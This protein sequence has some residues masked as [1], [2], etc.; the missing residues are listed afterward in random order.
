MSNNANPPLG[1][2]ACF[3]FRSTDNQFQKS[4]W[5]C[6]NFSRKS[7]S[8]QKSKIYQC[9]LNLFLLVGNIFL[10]QTF[11]GPFLPWQIKVAKWPKNSILA[12]DT[13]RTD[14][15]KHLLSNVWTCMQPKKSKNRWQP[16]RKSTITKGRQSRGFMKAQRPTTTQKR[17][18]KFVNFGA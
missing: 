14:S 4:F 3:L 8:R 18:G 10:S 13:K 9:V 6:E 16:L 15:L 2:N 17:R 1:M 5:R 7:A 11:K 12:L